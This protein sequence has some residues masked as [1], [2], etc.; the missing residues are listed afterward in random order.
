MNVLRL[1]MS[2]HNRSGLTQI[3]DTTIGARTDEHRVHGDVL[4]RHARLQTHVRNRAFGGGTLGGVGDLV[5]FRHVRG[6]RQTLTGV[7]A[8]SHERAELGGVDIH[9]LVEHGIVIGLQRLPIL[10]RTIPHLTFRRMRTAL[11]VLECGLIGRNHAGSRTGLNGHIAYGHALIHGQVANR[12]AT[13]FDDVALAA[14]GADLG[15]NRQNDVL[16][17]SI[18]RQ[19]AVDVDGHGLERLQRQR[20]RGHNV[21]D[22]GST[23]AECQRTEC[24][25]R[26]SVRVTAHD[27][28][29]RLGQAQNRRECMDYALIGVTQ[30]VQ[31]HTE[32]LAVLL[33]SAQLQSARFIRIR[34]I[35][36]NSRSVVIFGSDELIHVTRLAASQTQTLKCL[37][38]GDLMHKHQVDVQ[39]VGRTVAA[40][41]H[42]MIGPDLLGQCRSHNVS[43]KNSAR[44]IV[45][46]PCSWY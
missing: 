35:D 45:F 4:D 18:R 28:H 20:L 42:Q 1:V 30:R 40:P 41:A 36:V 44:G 12:F 38:A 33:Q 31:S 11:Q 24:A 22:L 8:P 16:G 43:S 5:R 34:T 37:R 13:V 23:D 2:L 10:D 7:G 29:A 26:R 25:V 19:L 27:G 9:Y 14:A 15:D 46:A 39:Q 17:G 3:I 6:D 21:L 32:F